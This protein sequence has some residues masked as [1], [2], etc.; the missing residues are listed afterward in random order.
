RHAARACSRLD[1]AAAQ[2]S[3]RESVSTGSLHESRL[4]L[5]SSP[6]P[7]R[8][9]PGCAARRGLEMVD[10]HQKAE[11]ARAIERA[12]RAVVFTGA[13]IRTESGIPDFRSPG[14]IWARMAPID[15]SGFLAS[16]EARRE[17]WRR[18]FEADEMWRGA[19]PN[20]GHRAVAE[21]VHRGI[22]A[23]VI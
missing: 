7:S 4:L 19:R 15:F 8:G 1:L 23:A 5:L 18:R 14:G 12:R 20:R 6:D 13:G 9:R 17:T 16:E 10:D 21:L 2:K 22:A 11:L 3:N